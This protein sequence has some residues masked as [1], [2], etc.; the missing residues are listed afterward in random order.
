MSA[1]GNDSNKVRRLLTAA[2]PFTPLTRL[3]SLN[4]AGGGAARLDGLEPEVI[5]YDTPEGVRKRV[6]IFEGEIVSQ[7]P[8]PPGRPRETFKV[9]K[10]GTQ[11]PREWV[12]EGLDIRPL[13]PPPIQS[14][15]A[16]E[17]VHVLE[18]PPAPRAVVMPLVRT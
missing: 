7:C 9:F 10:W 12:I 3:S 6:N 13:I 4:T 18:A 15:K 5:E 16:T 1:A 11:K 8:G 14:I 17:A 2:M